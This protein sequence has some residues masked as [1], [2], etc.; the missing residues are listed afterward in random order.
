MAEDSKKRWKAFPLIWEEIALNDN[1]TD[2]FRPLT[3][4][5]SAILL[6]AI[7]HYRWPTR[8]V[9]LGISEQELEK[10]IAEI[11]DRL[12]RES[13]EGGDMA[14]K[15][16]IRDGI[17]EAANRI[18]LQIATGQYA[19]IGLSTDADGTVTQDT[20]ASG[21]SAL[22]DDDPTTVLDEK[23]ASRYG[24]SVELADKIE[25][26]L[27]K[28]DAYY[29]ATNGTPVT[30]LADA[31][32]FL[33]SYFPC[34]IGLALTLYYDYRMANPRILFDDS[35]SFA[36]YIYC[37]GNDKFAIQQWFIDVSGYATPKLKVVLDLLAS[38]LSD[39]YEKYT[40]IGIQKPSNQY[41]DAACVPIPFQ[42]LDNMVFGVARPTT[43]VKALHR[44]KF[45]ITG[46][47]LDVDGDIQDAMWYRTAAGVLTRS[48]WQFTHSA[49]S[50]LP[51]DN[52]VP[53]NPAH[54]YEYTIDL[55]NLAANP[56]T[57][58]PNKNAGMNAAGLTYP[59]PFKIELTDIGL[60][61]S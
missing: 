46:Y 49:G 9:G 28:V 14:T 60:S 37:H 6:G 61:V 34:A 23:E 32:D 38:L 26:L 29:G 54:I 59:T 7:E 22:P 55:A 47:A 48:N 3:E 15:E 33:E 20:G 12:M 36:Q 58:T 2:K 56:I 57:I 21:D 44:M 53:Y 1:E 42:E 40:A 17:Y 43:I 4:R 19:N 10:E 50:N 18:A 8:W 45:K 51:S 31:T 27:D 52:Q 39:F 11:K 13:S 30:S 16:D 35:A 25:L 41:L 5:Q 24:A